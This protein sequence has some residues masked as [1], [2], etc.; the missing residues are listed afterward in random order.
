[1]INNMLFSAC[2]EM[3]CTEPP[4]FSCSC[5]EYL[6]ICQNHIAMHLISSGTHLPASFCAKVSQNEK[7]E[8]LRYLRS[9]G[10]F[11][12]QNIIKI[13]TFSEEI[14]KMI[15]NQTACIC[16]KLKI[17][18]KSINSAIKALETTMIAHKDI[19]KA[20][21][22][23]DSNND[24]LMNLD[25]DRVSN[26][27][28]KIYDVEPS[29]HSLKDDSYA[30][31]FKS[32]FSNQVDLIDLETFKTSSLSFDAKDFTLSCGCCK[33]DENKY[34]VYG[35]CSGPEVSDSAKIIDINLKTV[36]ILPSD[37]KNA[38]TGVCLC[39]EEVYCF[40]GFFAGPL[41]ICKKFDLKN[42]KW[43]YIQ[44][45]PEIS[46]CTT[47]STLKDSILVAGYNSSAIFI[48]DILQNVFKPSK[49]NFTADSWK[50]IF[51]NW[52]VVFGNALFEIDKDFNFVKRQECKDSGSGL[53][54]CA[55]FIRGD[56]LY[57]TLYT[58]KIYRIN[59][60]RKIIESF[61]FACS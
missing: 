18:Q 57:F 44:Q 1:M 31:Y 53:N 11:I 19:L 8:L 36:E 6:Y 49:D 43:I 4:M 13:I 46:Q 33:I 3:G 56:Y 16:K 40:G 50:Y 60:E 51:G 7:E 61:D 28:K 25:F 41:N 29:K 39:N 55:S 37:S 12:N 54:S 42:R 52:I 21:T 2:Y 15:T 17:E 59:R 9:K 24:Q 10:N 34:F 30:L 14:I 58:Q 35:G 26:Y 5:S 27:I 22:N 48:Y 38:M 32:K 23:K 20:V 47:A 45:L